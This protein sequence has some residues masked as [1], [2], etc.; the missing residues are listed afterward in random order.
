MAMYSRDI[1]NYGG[2]SYLGHGHRASSVFSTYSER[3]YWHT[4][5]PV[6]SRS[7]RS[8]TP[9]YNNGNA[10]HSRNYRAA[11]VNIQRKKLD[12]FSYN[13]PPQ[14]NVVIKAGFSLLPPSISRTTFKTRYEP[15]PAHSEP[16]TESARLSAQIKDFLKRSDHIEQDWVQMHPNRKSQVNRSRD[17]MNTS[18]AIRGYQMSHSASWATLDGTESSIANHNSDAHSL[19]DLHNVFDEDDLSISQATDIK[20]CNLPVPLPVVSLAH[21]SSEA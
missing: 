5:S 15:S 7:P 11:S 18:I 3:D 9:R 16:E 20:S 4:S 17:K 6:S 1:D 10:T 2:Q 14:D 12:G 21:S 13:L 19:M 8:Q